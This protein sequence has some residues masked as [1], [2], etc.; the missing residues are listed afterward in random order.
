MP[1]REK[2]GFFLLWAKNG[3]VMSSGN[4]PLAKNSPFVQK[5]APLPSDQLWL[6]F[7][8]KRERAGAEKRFRLLPQC[9]RICSIMIYTVA[10]KTREM[11][12]VKH[13]Y[14][15]T[16]FVNCFPLHLICVPRLPK[17]ILTQKSNVVFVRKLWVA[18]KRTDVS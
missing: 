6:D 10:P 12:S 4:F 1:I 18:L 9:K 17:N 15:E 8:Q 5:V 11:E 14:N 7:V 16:N 3:S 13:L 2:S